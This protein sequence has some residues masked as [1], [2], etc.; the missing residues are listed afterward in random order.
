MAL[1]TLRENGGEAVKRLGLIE[2]TRRSERAK[3]DRLEGELGKLVVADEN[4]RAVTEKLNR[5]VSEND[6]ALAADVRALREELGAS[7]TTLRQ[8]ADERVARQQ[9]SIEEALAL[10]AQARNISS[11]L[12]ESYS[13]LR[14]RLE[15]AIHQL[16]TSE[17]ERL[18]RAAEQAL[19]ELR[20][21]D[22]RTRGEGAGPDR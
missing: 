9:A 7:V 13:R 6:A 18:E 17:M 22:E 20:S 19:Q 5:V 16:T 3:V 2:E 14:A 10:A 1:E 8:I 11:A 15:M 4:L 12:N 21:Y